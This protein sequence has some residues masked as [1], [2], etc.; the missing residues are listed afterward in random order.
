MTDSSTPLTPD[1]A[2]RFLNK[3]TTWAPGWSV[4]ATASGSSSFYGSNGIYSELMVVLTK[5][6]RNSSEVAPNGS[7]PEP[8]TLRFPL[9]VPEFAMK[10]KD[11][12]MFWVLEKVNW[13]DEHENREFARYRLPDGSWYAPF[14]P[15]RG[16][17]DD[18]SQTPKW[19]AQYR[20]PADKYIAGRK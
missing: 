15:H 7:Y 20:D 18:Q 14:H 3:E 17:Y 13:C 8:W 4:S 2:A 16:R 1:E 5:E 10:D 9:C 12:L 19:Q 6:G 11:A